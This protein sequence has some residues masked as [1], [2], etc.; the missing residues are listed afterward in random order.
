VLLERGLS[1]TIREWLM[2]A[3]Y[4]VAKGNHRV[5]PCE[6]GIRTFET[7]IRAHVPAVARAAVAAV[8]DALIVEVHP[9]P[10]KALPDGHQSLTPAEFDELVK[11]VRVIAGAIGRAMQRWVKDRPRQG[12]PRGA[13]TSYGECEARRGSSGDPP[14]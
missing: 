13:E 2:A 9:R 4:I 3:E 1:A 7:G 8:A 10:E 12:V 5:A 6:R 11:Q 14:G